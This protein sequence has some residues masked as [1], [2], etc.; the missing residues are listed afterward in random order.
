M[1]IFGPS[2]E[3][4]QELAAEARHMQFA[5]KQ[6]AMQAGAV[7]DDSA[8]G[9]PNA[10]PD[11]VRWQQDLEDEVSELKHRLRRESWNDVDGWRSTGQQPLLNEL[12]V[13]MIEEELR[14]LTSRNM[15]NSNL[16]EEFIMFILRNTAD[17]I[18]DNLMFNYDVYEMDGLQYEHIVRLVKNAMCAAPFRAMNDGERRHQREIVKRIETH[19]DQQPQ[20]R[21]I[22]GIP[23]GS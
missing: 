6:A 5:E 16:S 14:P 11:L 15:I 22:L 17:V 18:A 13:A 9:N 20:Q 23:V 12:G 7:Q 19:S 2:A 4:K 10:N 1:S 3:V 8:Y 21:K